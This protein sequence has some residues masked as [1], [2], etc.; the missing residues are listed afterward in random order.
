M[1][2]V[3]FSKLETLKKSFTFRQKHFSRIIQHRLNYL[4]ISNSLQETISIEYILNAFSADHSS[5]FCFFIKYLDFAEGLSFWKFNNLLICNC[6][7]VDEMKIFIHSTNIFLHQN[8]TLSNQSKWKSL[9]YEICKRSVAFS[10]ALV[11]KSKK[12]HALLLSKITKLE[13]DIDSE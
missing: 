4:F 10:K 2:Y 3:I 11:K 13:Q 8:D 12:E 5:V 1:T 7:F 9:K 6:N